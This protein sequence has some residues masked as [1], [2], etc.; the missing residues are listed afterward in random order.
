MK[1]PDMGKVY[2]VVGNLTGLPQEKKRFALDYLLA[3]MH[4]GPVRFTK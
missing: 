2:T 1:Q 3:F 4:G